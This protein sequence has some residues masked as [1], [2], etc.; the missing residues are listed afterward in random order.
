M[1]KGKSFSVVGCIASVIAAAVLIAVFI[2]PGRYIRQVSENIQFSIQ[3]AKDAIF[4][5]DMDGAKNSIEDIYTEF[6]RKQDKLKLMFHH[7]N[8]DEIE[9]CISC[10]RDL[11]KLGQSDNLICELNQLR[12]IL[13]HMESM[14]HAD[15][16][17]IF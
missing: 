9:K 13:M 16:Y 5:G 15:M 2:L 12:Q 10:C 14:E 6:S 1:T 8:I 3:L 7:D 4:T 11:A 17:D